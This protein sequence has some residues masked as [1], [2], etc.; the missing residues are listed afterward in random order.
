MVNERIIKIKEEE[1]KISSKPAA[2]KN[3][4]LA[5]E[6]TSRNS[7]TGIKIWVHGINLFTDVSVLEW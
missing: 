1:K 4:C 5:A 3:Y 7:G 6:L 2:I